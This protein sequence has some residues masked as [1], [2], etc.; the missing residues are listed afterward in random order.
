MSVSSSA[1]AAETAQ[2]PVRYVQAAGVAT[3]TLNRPETM[4]SLDTETKVALLDALRRAA[5]DPLVRCVVLTGTGRAFSVGQDLREHAR[6]LAEMPNDDVWSTVD[7]HYSPIVRTLTTMDK[8]VV[9]AVNGVAA[10]A[11]M[12]IAMACDLRVAADT[13]SFNTAFTAV[14]LSCDTGSS[15]T[16][17]R[18]VGPTKAM[19]LLLEPRSIDAVTAER[20]GLVNAVVPAASLPDEV[21][22][23]AGRLARGATLA[24]AAVKRSLA[25]AAAHPLDDA[26]HFEAQMMG[27]TGSTSDHRRAVSSFLAKEKPTF[28]G[29]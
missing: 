8:P 19:E 22:G 3:I 25:Y 14:G 24:F 4:N 27:W 16:L 12:S 9:A 2:A 1:A 17:Q 20:I 7:E 28:E 23:L 5:G 6:N 13:A 21:A 10:G 29:T 15:W 26:L 11:G 18:L